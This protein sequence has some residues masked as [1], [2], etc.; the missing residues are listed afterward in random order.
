MWHNSTFKLVQS[1]AHLDSVFFS[2]VTDKVLVRLLNKVSRNPFSINYYFAK[3]YEIMFAKTFLTIKTS[4]II[5]AKIKCTNMKT[6]RTYFGD[7][8]IAVSK[9]TKEDW[10]RTWQK[11]GRNPALKIVFSANLAEIVKCLSILLSK[12]KNFRIGGG[13][14]PELLEWNI[15]VRYVYVPYGHQTVSGHSLSQVL[16]GAPTSNKFWN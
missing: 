6:F 8:R 7:D 9:P 15:L 5:F 14:I 16:I 3:F 12:S 1:W 2:Q 13:K 11:S 4:F 10:R